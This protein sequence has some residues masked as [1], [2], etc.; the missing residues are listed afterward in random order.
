M[1]STERRAGIEDDTPQLA[2]R[3]FIPNRVPS[4]RL[5][6]LTTRGKGVKLGYTWEITSKFVVNNWRIYHA[7][8]TYR[9]SQ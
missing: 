7:A 3:L 8:E 5:A 1:S 2:A 6:D 4:L 9:Y